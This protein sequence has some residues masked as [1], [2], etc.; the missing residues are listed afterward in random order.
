[1]SSTTSNV[2]IRRRCN[3]IRIT[4]LAIEALLDNW[5]ALI[6]N[7]SRASPQTQ[8]PPKTPHPTFTRRLKK[9]P[10][11]LEAQRIYRDEL[12]ERPEHLNRFHLPVELGD[13]YQKIDHEKQ[14]VLVGQPC[15][16]M[17]RMDGKRKPEFSFVTLLPI[18]GDDPNKTKPESTTRRTV[19]EL[20]AFKGGNP[21]WVEM[22][23]PCLVPVESVDYCA[24]NDKGIG[25]A[26]FPGNPP[27]WILPSWEERWK[28][29]VETAETLRNTMNGKN[30]KN[31][32]VDL[33]K[34]Q[35]GVRPDCK[36]KPSVKGDK[37][38]LGLKRTGRVLSPYARALLTSYSAHVA[39]DA[40]EPAIA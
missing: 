13:I 38:D 37:F 20:P 40:F 3:R 35:F 30:S 10:V 25:L 6:T 24:L 23:R 9:N 33:L 5:F 15:D 26:P 27:D 39:R 11:S 14:F 31:E 8:G 17:V 1:V 29:L 19:F 32:R 7:T 34:A 18:R 22:D 4:S 2:R 36:A 12:Y 28:L 21:A 16:L